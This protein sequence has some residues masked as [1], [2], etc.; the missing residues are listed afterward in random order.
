[1]KWNPLPWFVGALL[2][3][4]IQY[5]RHRSE[6]E[7]QVDDDGYEVIKLK[8]PWQVGVACPSFSPLLSPYRGTSWHVFF[9]TAA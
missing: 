3:L 2:L 1:M 6:K 9:T 5:R 7:V 8:G 4:L